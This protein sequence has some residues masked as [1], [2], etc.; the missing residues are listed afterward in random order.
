MQPY[1]SM[2]YY[3]INF[4]CKY[5]PLIYAIET[6]KHAYQ[7]GPSKTLKKKR[8]EKCQWQGN[9]VQLNALEES[10]P[11]DPKIKVS[12][13]TRQITNKPNNSDLPLPP[14]IVYLVQPCLKE[15]NTIAEEE[16]WE[17]GR[18]FNHI[19]SSLTPQRNIHNNFKLQ[20]SH[21]INKDQ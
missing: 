13:S 4:I 15:T 17:V 10:L 19:V 14:T 7:R 9:F 20:I 6:L 2:P 12:G 16:C 21:A 3:M 11:N 1:E 18:L 8:N 5:I